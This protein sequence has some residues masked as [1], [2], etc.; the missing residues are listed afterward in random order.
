M[1]KRNLLALAVASVCREHRHVEIDPER[2]IL[3]VT[4]RDHA[5]IEVE[6]PH[7]LPAV[8]SGDWAPVPVTRERRDDAQALLTFG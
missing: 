4:S 6:D 3:P 2:I 8:E 1:L 5:S 7:Q